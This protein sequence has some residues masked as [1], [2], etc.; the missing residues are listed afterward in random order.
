MSKY[1]KIYQYVVHLFC[2]KNN[3]QKKWIQ[4]IQ[5]YDEDFKLSDYTPQELEELINAYQNSNQKFKDKYFD[6][7]NDVKSSSLKKQDW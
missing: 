7:Y 1:C 6:F 5:S 3:E 2:M 4:I